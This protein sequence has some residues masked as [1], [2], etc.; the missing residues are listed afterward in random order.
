MPLRLIQLVLGDC[1]NVS[2]LHFDI[3]AKKFPLDV[4]VRKFVDLSFSPALM[5][6]SCYNF[7][8]E[9]NIYYSMLFSIALLQNSFGGKSIIP[10]WLIYQC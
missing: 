10:N 9:S 7:D 3:F 6:T 8:S 4:S 1:L 5:Y 2:T